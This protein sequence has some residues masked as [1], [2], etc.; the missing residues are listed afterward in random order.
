MNKTEVN[1]TDYVYSRSKDEQGNSIPQYYDIKI[2]N[3]DTRKSLGLA[4]DVCFF[5]E[6]FKKQGDKNLLNL[7]QDICNMYKQVNEK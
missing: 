4:I 7:V 1:V 5:S 6:L 3:S 2:F